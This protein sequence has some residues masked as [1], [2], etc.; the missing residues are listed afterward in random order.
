MNAE[1]TRVAI[2][3]CGLIGGSIELAI[4]EC[5]PGVD[6]VPL[7][8]DDDL[9]GLRGTDLVVLATPIRQIIEILPG[10]RRHIS[11]QTIVTDTGSTKAAIV[12][13]AGDMRF[14]GGHPIAGAATGG[15]E[16]ARADLFA[17]RP[18]ILT[19]ARAAAADVT[20]LRQFLGRLG[21]DVRL[22]DAAEHDRL[23]ALISHLP[24]VTV[25]AAMHV[26]G[27]RA[28]ASGLALAGSGLH[29]SSRLAGSPPDIWRDI[30]L[31]NRTNIT[32]AIDALITVLSSLRDDET[33]QALA[34][35]FE[36]AARWKRVL[37]G[38]R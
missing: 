21:A 23:L 16:A 26:I 6:V 34:R 35:T 2:V 1:F 27:S 32:S 15:R 11:T 22:L 3:G 28:G 10:L 30:L 12:E 36:S 5:L 9:D 31:T 20:R 37:D 8:R 25:S 38:T 33:G 24:Q 13:A 4:R 17:G 29:D 18:W 19:P 7:D 14:V